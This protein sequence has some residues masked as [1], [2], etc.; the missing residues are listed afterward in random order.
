MN[1]SFQNK[2]H[3]S[4]KLDDC[5]VSFLV[6]SVSFVGALSYVILKKKPRNLW[7][8]L[9]LQLSD[10]DSSALQ[11]QRYFLTCRQEASPLIVEHVFQPED[12][13]LSPPGG[14]LWLQG[15]C[16]SSSTCRKNACKEVLYICNIIQYI[17]KYNE[18]PKSQDIHLIKVCKQLLGRFAAVIVFKL[19]WWVMSKWKNKFY[20][21]FIKWNL[22]LIACFISWSHI[23]S[24]WVTLALPLMAI[25]FIFLLTV[26][27]PAGLPERSFSSIH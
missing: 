1:S 13:W 3:F 11:Q 26:C 24:N 20:S 4:V 23:Y 14:P 22:F 15:H 16:S 21:S 19:S 27:F 6:S 12:G 2:M 17:F 8:H 9:E 5:G 7:L 18:S 10:L 25:S